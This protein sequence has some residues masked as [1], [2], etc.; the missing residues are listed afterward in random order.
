[1]GISE[2]FRARLL[3]FR[4]NEITENEIHR[5]LAR[6]AP[7]AENRRVL[8]R[9]AGEEKRHYDVWKTYTKEDV[10]PD[11]WRIWKYVTISRIFGLT[12]G[13][14]LMERGEEDASDHYGNLRESPPE[15]EH[16]ARDESDHKQALIEL[17]DEDWMRYVGSI[18]LC[19]S[20][21]IQDEIPG[22]GRAQSRCGCSQLRCGIAPPWLAGC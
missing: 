12:F 13:I 1:M 10:K 15:A 18:V 11:R 21:A 6:A 5:R 2:E 9:I 4:R 20:T 3:G 14:R 8:E 7:S 17:I 19:Q 22:N 16:I